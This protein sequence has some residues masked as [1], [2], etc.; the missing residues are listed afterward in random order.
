VSGAR[1]NH[2]TKDNAMVT[3]TFRVVRSSVL[4]ALL[5]SAGLCACSETWKGLKE[6]TRENVQTTEQGL[7]KAGEN[8]KKQTQ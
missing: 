5:L 4:A 2:E 8:I 7:E 3:A 1:S 6:D